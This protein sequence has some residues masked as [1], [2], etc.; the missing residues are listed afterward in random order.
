MR[1]EKLGIL[2]L[3]ITV[4]TTAG[5]VSNQV[6]AQVNANSDIECGIA[7]GIWDP[8]TGDCN[9]PVGG[10]SVVVPEAELYGELAQQYSLWLI[11]AISAIGIGAYIVKRKI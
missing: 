10:M 4:L 6:F 7:G 5:F 11:P 2:F 9:F 8:Q 3:S 1:T